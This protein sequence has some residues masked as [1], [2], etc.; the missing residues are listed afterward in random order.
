MTEEERAR[1][2]VSIE[3]RELISRAMGLLGKRTSEKKKLSSRLNGSRPK[4]KRV[5][6]RNSPMKP[7]KTP[8]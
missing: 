6:T 2:L 1:A 4:R 5:K 3:E 8:S 7:N